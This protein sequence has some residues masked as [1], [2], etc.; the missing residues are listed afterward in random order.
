MTKRLVE[1]AIYLNQKIAEQLCNYCLKTRGNNFSFP[2]ASTP[3]YLPSAASAASIYPCN[4]SLGFIYDDLTGVCM[5]PVDEVV[6]EDGFTWVNGACTPIISEALACDIDHIWDDQAF[7]CVPLIQLLECDEGYAF[8]YFTAQCSPL[9]I[10]VACADGLPHEPNTGCVRQPSGT[11]SVTR[12]ATRSTSAT[13]SATRSATGTATATL[14][15]GAS[16]SGTASVTR[17]PT[18]SISASARPA[19]PVLRTSVLL[20]AAPNVTVDAGTFSADVRAALAASFAGAL[21]LSTA[22][23]VVTGVEPVYRSELPALRRALTAK[24]VGALR[25][26][27]GSGSTADVIGYRLLLQIVAAAAAR[28]PVIAAALNMT[29]ADL[30]A[31]DFTRL[32]SAVGEAVHGSSGGQREAFAAAL[33]ESQPELL[34]ALGYTNASQVLGALSRDPTRPATF[35][36][37]PSLTATPARTP[38]PSVLALAPSGSSGSGGLEGGSIAGI[39]IAVVVAV[40]LAGAVGLYI[41]RIVATDAAAAEARS[42]A[43][44]AAKEQST[45]AERAHGG[46]SVKTED[47]ATSP[48][49]EPS[50]NGAASAAVAASDDPAQPTAAV[51]ASGSQGKVGSGGAP[52]EVV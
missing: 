45:G 22:D 14:S 15:V 51:E 46:A 3:C 41:R 26:L 20:R 32:A 31:A 47:H 12:S 40:A 33:S 13:R 43:V 39:V 37:L 28:S 35:V 10:P 36:E 1:P 5:F 34:A 4:E 17:S 44:S 30:Q 42:V 8:N 24:T 11:P 29:A 9:I 38:T 6:C 50:S 19:V 48:S 25:A 18:P 21:N 7:G 23:V 52:V 49:E 27:Q 2:G 16:A